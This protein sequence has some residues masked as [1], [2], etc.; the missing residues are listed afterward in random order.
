MML[1][2]DLRVR[3]NIAL[4]PPCCLMAGLTTGEGKKL[5][6]RSLKKRA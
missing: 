3:T 2:F 5:D 6:G 4:V 1:W